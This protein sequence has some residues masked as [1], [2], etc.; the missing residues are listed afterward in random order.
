M[1][2]CL[3]ARM[4]GVFCVCVCAHMH[5]YKCGN[6]PIM[7]AAVHCAKFSNL[8]LFKPEKIWTLRSYTLVAWMTMYCKF[9]R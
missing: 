4:N 3:N 8:N 6:V 7:C 9:H 2:K 1:L 5:S